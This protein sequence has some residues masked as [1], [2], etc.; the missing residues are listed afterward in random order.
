LAS[1]VKEHD[2]PD[3]EFV[4]QMYIHNL[5]KLFLTGM[6]IEFGKTLWQLLRANKEF[7][8]NGV[9]WLF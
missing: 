1:A 6:D 9:L 7:P 8:T 5:E 4:N 3:K 2:F